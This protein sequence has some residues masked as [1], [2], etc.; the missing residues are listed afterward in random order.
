MP[1]V[2]VRPATVD[3]QPGG[4]VVADVPPRGLRAVHKIVTRHPGSWEVAFQ[5]D[6]VAAVRFWRRV[7]TEIARRRLG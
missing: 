7:A 3:D 4:A 2:S 1:E 6:N 5:D